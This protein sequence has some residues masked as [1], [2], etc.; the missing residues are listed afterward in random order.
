MLDIADA[1]HSFFV[2]FIRRSASIT[3]GTV[4]VA[5]GAAKIVKT[6]AITFTPPGEIIAFVANFALR[7]VGSR[8]C[9]AIA[10]D[11]QTFQEA[12]IFE[13][14]VAAF[15]I[16][17]CIVIKFTGGVVEVIRLTKLDLAISNLQK[18]LVVGKQIAALTP[19][20]FC[21][22]ILA[23]GAVEII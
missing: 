19:I 2:K 21:K 22:I 9:G 20:T 11:A 17:T 1:A 7:R 12:F 13:K 15:A 18:A 14:L 8:A 23:G 3:S 10:S 16:G 5:V 4:R 6:L